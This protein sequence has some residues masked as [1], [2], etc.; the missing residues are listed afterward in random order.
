MTAYAT[1]PRLGYGNETLS[2]QLKDLDAR[3][4][5]QERKYIGAKRVQAV[6][7]VKDQRDLP[8]PAAPGDVARVMSTGTVMTADAQ[9]Q[10]K[11]GGTIPKAP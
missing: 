8:V 4:I 5:A 11:A 2:G 3:L 10:W 9:G 7:C 6:L 1:S